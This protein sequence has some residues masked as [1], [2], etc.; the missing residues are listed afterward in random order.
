MNSVLTRFSLFRFTLV[1]LVFSAA[2]SPLREYANGRKK[3]HRKAL[4]I[5]F[6]LEDNFERTKDPALGYPPTERLER[7]L[8]YAR[9]KQAEVLALAK[10]P[11]S[12]GE[13]RWRERGPDNYA[14]RTRAILIDQQD[15]TRRTVWAGSVS[16]GL[17]KCSNIEADPPQWEIVSDFLENMAVGSL[18]QDP[19]DPQ[20]IYMGTGEGFNNLDAVRGRGIY[21]TTDGGNTWEV[22]PSTLATNF[23]FTRDLFVHPLT[24]DVYAATNQGLFRSQNGGESWTRI[25]GIP[26]NIANANMYDIQYAPATGMIYASNANAIWRSPGG[27]PGTWV[28]IATTASGFPSGLNRVEMTLSASNPDII[29]IIGETGGAASNV[30]ITT[31]GGQSWQQRA[32]PNNANGSEFTNGQAWYD[33]EIAVDP[34]DPNHVIAGG[35]R[36]MR[37]VNGG[38]SWSV[39]ANNM[40]VDHH[41]VVFDPQ[42]QGVIYFGNDGGIY[43]S[44]SGS[45]ASVPSRKRNF[46]V[47]QFY[48]CALHPEAGSNYMLGGTQD[49]NSLQLNTQGLG[50]ARSVRGGDGMFCHIDQLDPN[51]QMV[52]SQNGNYSLST[53][54][55]QTFSNAVSLDGRF[56]CPSDY[57]SQAKIM[58]SQTNASGGSFY[59]WRV[60]TGATELVSIQPA[61]VNISAITVDPNTPNRVYFGS[62]NNGRIIRVDNAHEGDAVTGVTLVLPTGT[63]SSIDVE[64]GNPDHLLATVSNYGVQSVFESFNGGVNWI[65]VEGDLPDMPVRWGIFNP[66]NNRQAMIATEAGVWATELLD[67]GNTE[68]LPPANSIGTPL[69][70]T[71]MLQVRLSDRTVLAATHGRGLYT[72]DAFAAPSVRAQ[73]NPVVYKDVPQRYLGELSTGASTFA[74]DFGDG[75]TSTQENPVHAYSNPGEYVVTLTVNGNLTTSN[76]VKVLPD[77]PLPYQDDK[78][79][80]GGNFEGFTEQYAVHTLSGSG[81]ERGKSTIPK[82]DGTRSGDQAFVTGLT[83]P[84]YQAN[85]LSY[86]YLSNFDFSENTLYDFSFWAKWE[87]HNGFDG[88]RVEYSLDK[89]LSWQA[90]NDAVSPGWYNFRNTNVN[91][92]AFPVGSSYFS[93]SRTT[94]EQYKT[95]LSF[96]AGNANVAFRFVFQSDGTGSHA[97]LAIDDVRINKYEGPLLTQLSRFTGEFVGTTDIRL[98]WNTTLEY[99]C[100]RFEIE[101]SVNGRDFERIAIVNATGVTTT[102]LQ[103]YNHTGPGLRNLYFY[104]LRVISEDEPNG[105]SY[106]FY[107]PVVI[108]QRS[109]PSTLVNRVFPGPFGNVLGVTFNGLIDTPIDYQLFDVAGRLVMEGQATAPGGF[110]EI[111]TG[112]RLARAMYLLRIKAGNGEYETHKVVGGW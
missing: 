63:V 105:Y 100:R 70:R 35:V 8:D 22:L 51:I 9:R 83:E 98:E 28:N 78:P 38:S 24:R 81:F 59:R 48:A 87:I 52:S 13:A 15:P 30:F 57:D 92:A 62:F 84:F 33:L 46:N 69:V 61:E 42:Q 49:N 79:M 111:N 110:L 45:S 73:F 82:K 23:R 37:S 94:W 32:R 53:D 107:S 77:R 65:N 97:G 109:Q 6:A 12:L 67:G 1:L 39:F 31:D 88:F 20:V 7:A 89:G 4:S 55:G 27:N 64:Y 50:S 104:R 86:L 29:Y 112:N 47:T 36:I 75:T 18:A 108:M 16:G 99:F 95:N 90:L 68:W 34:F 14:G 25:L 102:E 58:Y 76:T 2:F 60:L 72:T 103:T 11:N 10:G 56:I 5:R 3:E 71:D 54:G 19:I 66:A 106:V 26:A 74:W 85:S 80:Y 101:R 41:K 17:W 44:T 91:G 93:S 40:H 21:R 96:L 43:R